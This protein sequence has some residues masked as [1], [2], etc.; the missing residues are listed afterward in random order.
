M[1][2][3]LLRLNCDCCLVPMIT[4]V[5]GKIIHGVFVLG[6]SYYSGSGWYNDDGLSIYG[7]VVISRSLCSRFYSISVIKNVERASTAR[8]G[9]RVPRLP[10]ARYGIRSE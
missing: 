3:Q 7:V 6:R 5:I 9:A 4:V 8:A 2:L 1:I 10:R